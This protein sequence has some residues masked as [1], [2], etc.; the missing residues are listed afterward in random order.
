MRKWRK[1]LQLHSALW[2]IN[3]KN[4]LAFCN[5][6][7]HRKSTADS[8]RSLNEP[9][10]IIYRLSSFASCFFCLLQWTYFSLPL[11]GAKWN[12]SLCLKQCS[13]FFFYAV[14]SS[15]KRKD[16]LVPWRSKQWTVLEFRNFLMGLPR[17]HIWFVFG[18]FKQKFCRKN[19]ILQRDLNSDRWCRSR[20][21]W[22]LTTWPHYWPPERIVNILWQFNFV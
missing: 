17:S 19:C 12:M 8:R 15:D 2:C 20:L 11:E 9:Q 4:L 16:A 3:A 10:K 6:T 21:T 5:A 13:L 1:F 18:L 7:G 14:A 22:Q